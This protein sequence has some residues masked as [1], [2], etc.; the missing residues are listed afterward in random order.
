MTLMSSSGRLLLP[1]NAVIAGSFHLVMAPLKILASV[2][3]SHVRSSVDLTL[4]VIAIGPKTAGRFHA[5][6]PPQRCLAPAYSSPLSGESEPP[7]S[8]LA[9]MKS[10]TPAPDP[11][12]E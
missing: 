7:K 12:A 8:V 10:E 1:F 4:N 6:L 11:V 9:P 3:A 5:S 2:G